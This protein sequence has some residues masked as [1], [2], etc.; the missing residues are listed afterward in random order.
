MGETWDIV[1]DECRVRLWVAQDMGHNSG[2]PSFYLYG[3]HYAS[4]ERQED[5][6]HYSPLAEF[7]FE[8]QGHPLRFLSDGADDERATDYLILDDTPGLPV[9]K[10]QMSWVADPDGDDDPV[11]PPPP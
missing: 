1:C 6:R 5:G 8:H 7:L 2:K 9:S 10:E 3:G 11:A 4:A